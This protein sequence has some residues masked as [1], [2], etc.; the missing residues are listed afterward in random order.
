MYTSLA[1]DGDGY[2]HVS[3]RDGRNNT[4]KYAYQDGSGW[5]T[6]I[7]DSEVNWVL[8]TSLALDL[9]RPAPPCRLDSMSDVTYPPVMESPDKPRPGFMERLRVR[10]CLARAGCTR[11]ALVRR[12]PRGAI[13]P[14]PYSRPMPT[15]GK[16]C[17]ELRILDAGG[18]WRIIYRI[19]EDAIVIPDVHQKK[20]TAQTPQRVIDACRQRLRDYDATQQEY[21]MKRAKQKKLERRGPGPLAPWRTSSPSRPR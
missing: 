6:H 11:G 21:G 9:L 16:R 19:D 20:K 7:V 1:L 10:R 2:P 4:L 14:M 3:Y 13:L 12:L 8:S 5:H 18:I 17:H 15:I